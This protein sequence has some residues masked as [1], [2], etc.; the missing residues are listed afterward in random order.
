MVVEIVNE[1]ELPIIPYSAHP[2][3]DGESI[4]MATGEDKIIPVVGIHDPKDEGSE[5]ALEDLV[6]EHMVKSGDQ[7]G[8]QQCDREG[9]HHKEEGSL[10]CAYQ[11]KQECEGG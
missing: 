8:Q 9:H 11:A 1:L 7:H 4:I 5:H 2:H 6:G 3:K 10:Y